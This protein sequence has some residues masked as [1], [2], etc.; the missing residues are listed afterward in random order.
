MVLVAFLCGYAG[1]NL[2]EARGGASVKQLK[3]RT[4]QQAQQQ[5]GSS[6]GAAQRTP[7]KTPSKFSTSQRKQRKA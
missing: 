7:Q 3:Q 6:K 4:A 2:G 5:A 1:F